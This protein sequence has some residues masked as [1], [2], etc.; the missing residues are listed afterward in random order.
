MFTAAFPSLVPR[1]GES[2]ALLDAHDY[3]TCRL[4]AQLQ[5]CEL[6]CA[7]TDACQRRVVDAG[8]PGITFIIPGPDGTLDTSSPHV[9]MTYHSLLLATRFVNEQLTSLRDPAQAAVLR[10][11]VGVLHW[12]RTKGEHQR[13]A[14]RPFMEMVVVNFDNMWRGMQIA[15]QWVAQFELEQGAVKPSMIA[16]GMTATRWPLESMLMDAHIARQQGQYSQARRL[17]ERATKTFKWAPPADLVRAF[18]SPVVS[19]L[20]KDHE[21]VD[22]LAAAAVPASAAAAWSPGTPPPLTLFG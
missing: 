17:Y 1:H 6:L 20:F 2:L 7:L 22:T 14:M 3:T 16:P 18:L 13:S 5:Y 12:E 15:L 4:S 10:R 19:S 9:A 8:K 11:V 21:P